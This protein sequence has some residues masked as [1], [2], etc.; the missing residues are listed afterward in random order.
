MLS[1]TTTLSMVSKLSNEAPFVLSLTCAFTGPDTF[2]IIISLFSKKFIIWIVKPPTLRIAF[3]HIEKRNCVYSSRSIEVL[4]V[5]VMFVF[6]KIEFHCS[7]SKFK[8]QSLFDYIAMYIFSSFLTDLKIIYIKM[9]SLERLTMCWWPAVE[10]V[11]VGWVAVVAEGHPVARMSTQSLK[12]ALVCS[13]CVCRWRHQ[14]RRAWRQKPRTGNCK[15][16]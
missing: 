7:S 6:R 5:W 3:C 15:R 2:L 14:S 1:L 9:Y 13:S 16:N 10:R 11:R 4:D 8:I 12:G